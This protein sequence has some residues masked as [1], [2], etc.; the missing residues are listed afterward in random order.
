MLIG[1]LS[2]KTGLSKD[3]IR[4]YEKEGLIEAEKPVRKVFFSNSYKDYTDSTATTLFFI[5][6]AK[7]L[8]FTLAEIGEMLALRVDGRFT[9]ER[10]SAE[11]EAKLLVIDRKIGEL[12]DLKELLGSVLTSCIDRCFEDGC[13]ILDDAVAK[14][15]HGQTRSTEEPRAC[16]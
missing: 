15:G 10:W 4:F 8:G 12:Q 1:E 7:A 2:K 14:T 13:G 11:A 3:T 5:Q 16:C 9:K 6:R